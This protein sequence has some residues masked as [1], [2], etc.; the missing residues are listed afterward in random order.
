MVHSKDVL[1]PYPILYHATE[2]NSC[3]LLKQLSC[4][5]M[6]AFIAYFILYDLC[7]KSY[8]SCKYQIAQQLDKIAGVLQYDTTSS[9]CMTN[10]LCHRITAQNENVS[11]CTMLLSDCMTNIFCHHL[12]A[13]NKNVSD[14][15]TLLSDCTTDMFCHHLIAWNGNASDC[16]YHSLPSCSTELQSETIQ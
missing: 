12:I 16:T 13:H 3:V 15:T 4:K 10:M 6:C 5:I 8:T 7:L 1:S 11:D 2:R 14:C 9:D